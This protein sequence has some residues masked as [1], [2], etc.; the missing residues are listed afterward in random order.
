MKILVGCEESQA[1]TIELRKLGHEAY[2]CDL[3]ECSGGHPEWHLKMDVFTAVELHAWEVGIFFP[4]CTYLTC[5]A[6]WAYKQPPYHQRV[7]EGTLT[8]HER[9]NA[10]N[11]AIEFVKRL[12]DCGINQVAIENPVG[13]L[14]T[15][16]MK[17]TQIIQP[18]EYGD[19]A[20][21]KTCLWLKGLPCLKPTNHIAG[22]L[23]SN[24]E[25]GVKRRWGNQTNSGQNN[26]PPSENRAKLRSKTYQGISKAMAKQ[27][28]H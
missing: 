9:K 7:K 5:S 6:E 3:Q 10:R 22:R 26:L 11:A 24:G 21:K 23:V 16:W 19:D 27:W 12:W 2:S 1:V 4:D 25:G 14:S 15:Q 20:S 17:P 18:Y 8:G 13:V 28:T